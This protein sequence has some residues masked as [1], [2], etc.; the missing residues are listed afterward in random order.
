MYNCWRDHIEYPRFSKRLLDQDLQIGHTVNMEVLVHGSPALEVKWY[1]NGLPLMEN[2]N[3]HVTHY[4]PESHVLTIHQALPSDRGLYSC[5]ASNIAG[6]V[7][8]SCYVNVT[9]HRC[10]YARPLGS[11]RFYE[12]L[13][14]L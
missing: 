8:T 11:R 9:K 1:K 10:A 14:D 13:Y 6:T 12:K 2:A 3:C 4:S 7:R 5:M